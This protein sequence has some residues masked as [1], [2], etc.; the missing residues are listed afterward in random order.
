MFFQA[1]VH[2]YVNEHDNVLLYLSSV[3]PVL[4]TGEGLQGFAL[5]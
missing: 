5:Q 4:S 1:F 3:F 2:K